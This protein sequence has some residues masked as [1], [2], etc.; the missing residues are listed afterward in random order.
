[1]GPGWRAA[2]ST[3]GRRTGWTSCPALRSARTRPS[4]RTRRGGRSGRSTTASR[5]RGCARRHGCCARP[6]LTTGR[7]WCPRT[8]DGTWTQ[9]P[10][11][12]LQNYYYVTKDVTPRSGG[13]RYPGGR[14]AGSCPHPDDAARPPSARLRRHVGTAVVAPATTV[15][16][17]LP[18]RRRGRGLGAGGGAGRSGQGRGAERAGPGGAEL[19]TRAITP[20]G[21]RQT[22]PAPPSGAARRSRQRHLYVHPGRGKGTSTYKAAGGA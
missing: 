17:T 15:V 6:V 8:S 16:P 13:A 3:P 10:N 12:K 21:G 11:K 20:L 22:R 19:P 7:C 4:R 9:Y 18:L 2:T 1:M 14:I 5:R